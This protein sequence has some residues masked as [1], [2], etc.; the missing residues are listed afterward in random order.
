MAKAGS[1]GEFSPGRAFSFWGRQLAAD[2]R[3]TK[4]LRRDCFVRGFL[5]GDV[6][7]SKRKPAR[8]SFI[9]RVRRA[10]DSPL[11]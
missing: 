6:G 7:G 2:H 9:T 8:F 5:A 4:T 1:V 11:E 3:L 10:G